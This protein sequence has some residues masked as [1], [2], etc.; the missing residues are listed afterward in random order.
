MTFTTTGSSWSTYTINY[1]Y[2]TSATTTTVTD[3][4]W[5][6]DAYRDS[7]K[8]YQSPLELWKAKLL[9]KQRANFKQI[10]KQI[11]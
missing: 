3:N 9:N 4:S 5:I 6:Y 1:S 2:I 10:P 7:F 11:L 8:R